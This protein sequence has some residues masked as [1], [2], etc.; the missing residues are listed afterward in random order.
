MKKG[1][2]FL[3]LTSFMVLLVLI[4][5]LSVSATQVRINHAVPT[6]QGY[7][8]LPQASKSLSS[9]YAGVCLWIK[10]PES[11]TFSARAKKTDGTWGA[12]QAGTVVYETGILYHVRYEYNL[13]IGTTV[14]ARFRNHNW[15]LNSNQIE[16]YFDY[17]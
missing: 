9:D 13:G 8:E 1:K 7:V 4:F 16:G 12:Y 5:T 17:L 15:S 14:Q 3:R 2:L 6:M 11:V 10:D